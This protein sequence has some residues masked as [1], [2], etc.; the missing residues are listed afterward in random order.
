[1]NGLLDRIPGHA[2]TAIARTL[3]ALCS[4]YFND[5][6]MQYR[7]NQLRWTQDRRQMYIDDKH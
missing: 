3:D 6:E 1:M 4:L 7:Q 2:N 5:L